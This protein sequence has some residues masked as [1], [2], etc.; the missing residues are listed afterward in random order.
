MVTLPTNFKPFLNRKVLLALCFGLIILT[1]NDS[2][3]LAA[4]LIQFNS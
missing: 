3:N 4:K 2:S 1:K